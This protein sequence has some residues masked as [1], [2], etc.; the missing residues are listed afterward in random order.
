MGVVEEPPFPLFRDITATVE[1]I[2]CVGSGSK[3]Q[4]QKIC[5]RIA[6]ICRN[7]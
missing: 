1:V 3:K 6:K 5:T 7:L 4:K 2:S